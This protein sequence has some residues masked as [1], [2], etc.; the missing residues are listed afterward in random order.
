VAGIK[1]TVGLTSRAGVVPIS[2]TQDTVGVHGRSLADAAAVLGTLT[3]PDA[4]DP[5]T[6]ASAGHF[7]PIIGSS[8]IR[9]ACAAHASASRGS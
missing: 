7:F 5:Q 3:G 2:H 4:R 1:P 8:S 6:A 9:T